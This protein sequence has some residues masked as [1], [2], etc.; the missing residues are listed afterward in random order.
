M[1][2]PHCSNLKMSCKEFKEAFKPGDLI[3]G[4]S[5]GK[6]VEIT[7]VGQQ[8]FLYI[9]DSMGRR[10]KEFVQSIAAPWMWKKVSSYDAEWKK[11]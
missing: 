8:R 5:T 1:S 2:C 10:N 4:W 6:V 3:Q 9:Q 7:A 11:C